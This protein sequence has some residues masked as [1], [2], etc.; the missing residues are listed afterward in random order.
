MRMLMVQVFRGFCVSLLLESVPEC[1]DIFAPTFSVRLFDQDCVVA[2]T[3]II[4]FVE[5]GSNKDFWVGLCS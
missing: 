1:E 5:I 2:Y 4:C 3:S